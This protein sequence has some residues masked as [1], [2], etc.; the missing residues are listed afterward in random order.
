MYCGKKTARCTTILVLLTIYVFLSASSNF[1]MT[2]LQACSRS[3]K[4]IQL[5]KNPKWEKHTCGEKTMGRT[6][7]R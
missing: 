7:V 2:K 3:D 5:V 6:L 1:T 4:V